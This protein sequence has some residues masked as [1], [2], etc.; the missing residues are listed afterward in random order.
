MCH[1]VIEYFHGTDMNGSKMYMGHIK[2]DII[3]PFDEISVTYNFFVY[4][5]KTVGSHR[6]DMV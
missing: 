4:K 6:E 1:G 2:F 3:S 5:L